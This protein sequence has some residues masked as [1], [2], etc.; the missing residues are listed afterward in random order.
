MTEHYLDNSATTQ[1]SSG[2]CDKILELLKDKYGN[3]SSLHSKGFEAERELE[4]ARAVIAESLGAQ[5]EEILF[6]SGGTEANNL[7]VL[8]GAEALRK[9]GNRIITTAY[10]HSSVYE[11]AEHLRTQGFDVVILTPNSEGQITEEALFDVLDDKTIL[12]SVM[13]VNNEVGSINPVERFSSLIKKKSPNALFHIDAVQAFGK[14]PFKVSKIKCDLLTV[15]AHKIHGPKGVGALF[16]RKGVRILPRLFGGKQER[17]L[18]PGTESLPLIAGFAQAAEELKVQESYDKISELS[19]YLREQLS[20]IEGVTINSPE[21]A[22]PYIVNFST[23][24]IRSETMLHFLAG[25]GVYVSSGSACSKGAKSHVLEALGLCDARIDTA[26]RV[27]FSKHSTKD[28][29]DALTEGV[30]EGINTLAKR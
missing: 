11:S 16:I 23:S 21:N 9:R 19:K 4:H 18:R 20:S 1:V 22:L 10:E 27:S 3:P 2:V 17:K 6:T 26:I 29:C 5:K 12:V 15:S 8:G 30:K 24:V 7:A 14:I 25:R 13:Y 28:D